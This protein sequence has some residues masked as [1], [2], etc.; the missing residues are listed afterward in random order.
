MSLDV[1]P[2]MG[3]ASNPRLIE[4]VPGWEITTAIL[5]IAQRYGGKIPRMKYCL[6]RNYLLYLN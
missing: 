4:G 3:E 1:L 5:K 2:V 6:E